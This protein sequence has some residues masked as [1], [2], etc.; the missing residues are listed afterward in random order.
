MYDARR[1]T[2]QFNH[3]YLVTDMNPIV[4]MTLYSEPYCHYDSVLCTFISGNDKNKII[5]VIK[6]L[7]ASWQ[8]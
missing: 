2:G 7:S 8:Y 6:Q 1:W 5:S 3:D 4:I